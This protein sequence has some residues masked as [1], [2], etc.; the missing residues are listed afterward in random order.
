MTYS[1]TRL[2]ER[3]LWC[4]TGISSHVTFIKME[5]LYS[6]YLVLLYF[7]SVLLFESAVEEGNEYKVGISLNRKANGRSFFK[8]RYVNKM[9]NLVVYGHVIVFNSFLKRLFYNFSYNLC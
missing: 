6:A 2:A 9:Y 8:E 5:D 3:H 1:I 4:H 7:N